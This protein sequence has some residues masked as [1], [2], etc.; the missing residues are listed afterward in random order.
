MTMTESQNENTIDYLLP[1]NHD[2]LIET[3]RFGT[4][5][6]SKWRNRSA[7]LIV[8]TWYC[9]HF[10]F[11]TALFM[12]R[13]SIRAFNKRNGIENSDTSGYHETLT[14][15]WVSLIFACIKNEF[16]PGSFQE[17]AQ[18]VLK[19][20]SE[21]KTIFQDYYSFD[22]LS[23]KEARTIW[24]PPDLVPDHRIDQQHSEELFNRLQL[25]LSK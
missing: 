14:V 8:G 15:F 24:I 13:D 17:A 22:V 9:F 19:K 16:C 18:L 5:P 2:L 1:E 10:D 21:D 7:H 23:S 6:V 12:L 3:F 20:Y 4:M 11:E 25:I